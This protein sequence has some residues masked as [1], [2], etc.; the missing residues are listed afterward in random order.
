MTSIVL[1]CKMNLTEASENQRHEKLLV[2]V[3]MQELIFGRGWNGASEMCLHITHWIALL[4]CTVFQHTVSFH[5]KLSCILYSSKCNVLLCNVLHCIT[6]HSSTLYHF[7]LHSPVVYRSICKF[8][9][10]M[11]C[12]RRSTYLRAWTRIMPQKSFNVTN[13]LRTAMLKSCLEWKQDKN[14]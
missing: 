10:A 2:N 3:C 7:T 9:S 12:D 1:L 5:I 8:Y 13:A 4:Y 14:S 6:L 11:Y